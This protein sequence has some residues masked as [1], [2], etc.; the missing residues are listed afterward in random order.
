MANKNLIITSDIL[1][2]F[3]TILLLILSVAIYDKIINLNYTYITDSG[4]NWAKGPLIDIIAELEFPICPAG[5]EFLI[6][7]YWSGTNKGCI[8]HPNP[9][10]NSTFTQTLVIPGDCFTIFLTD[11]CFKIDKTTPIRYRGWRSSGFCGKRLDKNYLDLMVVGKYYYCPED[12]KKCGYIDSLDNI[13][14]VPMNIECPLNNI[15]IKKNKQTHSRTVYH[16]NTNLNGD[17]LIE[18]KISDLTPCVDPN[19]ANSNSQMYALAKK[20]SATCNDTKSDSNSYDT[21]Y[22]KIDS[23]SMKNLYKDN[24]IYQIIKTL[25]EFPMTSLK[26]HIG[27]YYRSYIGI[28][29]ICK[30]KVLEETG[31]PSEY[32][33]NKLVYIEDTLKKRGGIRIH[34]IISVF[35][36]IILQI[37]LITKFTI[38]NLEAETHESKVYL[39]IATSI[40]FF[41]QF[42]NGLNYL[43]IIK[44]AIN[45]YYWLIK[46]DTCLDA[47]TYKN[48]N[49]FND[50]LKVPH[51]FCFLFLII[52]IISIGLPFTEY[53]IRNV[54]HE[55]DLIFNTENDKVDK[56]AYGD[57][58]DD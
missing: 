23:Y 53:L 41:L 11:K 16:S 30:Q 17:M 34:R 36:C 13:L 26:S 55:K 44:D 48:I 57:V 52:A 31:K 8:C 18:F 24:N 3:T 49:I 43:V 33:L 28:N 20:Y 37:I 51:N 14:C 2:S 56:I 1:S 15:K 19:L 25:P 47:F 42:C 5:Y 22:K 45:N 27:L 32:I 40:V 7:D 29:P 12:Y 9:S 54:S 50:M 39:N 35:F 4:N 46:D 58:H 38:I 10:L 21:R 6:S